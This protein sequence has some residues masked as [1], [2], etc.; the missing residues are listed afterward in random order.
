MMALKELSSS[1]LP[2][3]VNFMLSGTAAVISKCTSAPIERVK[4][5]VQ[6]QNELLKSER[7]ST[8][9]LSA[10]DCVRRVL[11]TEGLRSFW[12]GNLTNCIQYFNYQAINFTVKER[13][14]YSAFGAGHASSAS[15]SMVLFRHIVIGGAAGLCSGTLLYSLDYTRTR[16]ANDILLHKASQRQFTGILDVYRQTLRSDGVR[17]LYRGYLMTCATIVV[18]RGLY[19]GLY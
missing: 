13:I 6:S 15:L 18:Y 17:G 10:T 4:L 8:P 5:L 7:L 16:L 11:E 3:A 1:S 9:Y 2:N 19:F 14:K 12:R